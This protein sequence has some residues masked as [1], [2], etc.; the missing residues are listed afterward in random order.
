[1]NTND[2]TLERPK[3]SA[4]FPRDERSLLFISAQRALLSQLSSLVGIFRATEKN[5]APT[6]GYAHSRSRSAAAAHLYIYTI[7]EIR[8]WVNVPVIES[9]RYRHQPSIYTC[10]CITH[11]RTVYLRLCV[12][13]SQRQLLA[14]RNKYLPGRVC[15]DGLRDKGGKRRLRYAVRDRA[16]LCT[17]QI[18]CLFCI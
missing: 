3:Q 10:G 18:L 13:R 12:R 4:F 5:I 1:M 9:R 14:T 2:V 17:R 8:H 7:R 11:T 15:D 16:S 6:R